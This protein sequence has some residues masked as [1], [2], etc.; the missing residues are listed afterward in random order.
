MLRL[1]RGCVVGVGTACASVAGMVSWVGG[2]S[3]F[4][5]S[6]SEGRLGM[7]QEGKKVIVETVTGR[8]ITGEVSLD[9]SVCSYGQAVVII[10]GVPTGPCDM[11]AD[12]QDGQLCGVDSISEVVCDDE[13]LCFILENSGYRVRFAPI[14]SR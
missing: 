8:T 14:E 7:V 4:A 12:I 13:E 10:D 11:F 2:G 1:W 6:H 3:V 9:S 5:A